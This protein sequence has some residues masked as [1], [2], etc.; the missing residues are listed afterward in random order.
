MT[1]C[2]TRKGAFV[3]VKARFKSLLN[4]EEMVAGVD[5]VRGNRAVR[6]S[7]KKPRIYIE[8]PNFILGDWSDAN[9]KGIISILKCFFLASGLQINIHKSQVLGVGVPRLIVERAASNLGCSIMQ[10]QFRYLG[11]LVGACMSRKKAWDDIVT[12]LRSRLSKWKVKTL[13]IGGRLTLL[14]SVLGASPLYSMSIFKAP[15]GVLKE[16]E[17]VRRQFFYGADH[18]DNK[19]TWAAWNKILA[20]KQKGGL[21][22]SSFHALNRAL[23]LKWVWRFVSQDGSLW[24]R[25]IQAIYGNTITNHQFMPSHSEPSRWVRYIPIKINVFAWRARRDCLPTRV[26]LMRRGVT[27]DSVNCPFCNT[28]E[29]DIHHVLFRCE[30]A[31]AVMRRVC[32]WWTLDWQPWSS[33]SDWN[34]WFSNVRFFSKVKRVLEGVFC[35]AWWSL[36]KLRNCTI[37]DVSPPFRS[38]IFDDIVYDYYDEK[39]PDKAAS[40]RFGAPL[41]DNERSRDVN[42][43]ANDTCRL[44]LPPHAWHEAAFTR[45]ARVWGDVMFPKKCN[46]NNNNLVA[47]KGGKDYGEDLEDED[48]IFDDGSE[49]DIF[50]HQD[51]DNYQGE[52]G[53]I[54]DGVSDKDPGEHHDKDSP[55]KGRVD[56][57]SEFSKNLVDFECHANLLASPNKDNWVCQSPTHSSKNT[58]ISD[59][60]DRTKMSPGN[61]NFDKVYSRKVVVNNVTSREQRYVPIS[62][63]S[64]VDISDA[65]SHHVQHMPAPDKTKT[66]TGPIA[67]TLNSPIMDPS[68]IKTSPSKQCLQAQPKQKKTTKTTKNVKKIASLKL[69]HPAIGINLQTTKRKIPLSHTSNTA[70]SSSFHNTSIS[71]NDYSIQRCKTRLLKNATFTNIIIINE[72]QKTIDIGS[73]IGYDLAGK[74]EMESKY[75]KDDSSFIH[76]LWGFRSCG[77]AIKKSDGNSSGI[78]AIWNKSMFMEQNAVYGDVFLAAYGQWIHFNTPCLMIIVCAPQEFECKVALWNNLSN[79]VTNFNSPS[80]VFRDFNEVREEA[81]R[82]GS[83][84]VIGWATKKNERLFFLKVDFE[85]AFDSLDWKFL[86]HIM[87]QIGF[88]SAYASVLINGSPTKEFKINKGLRQGDPLS[89]FLFIFA[90]EALHVSLQEA[91]MKNVFQGVK[92]LRFEMGDHGL[93]GRRTVFIHSK[94]TSYAGVAGAS[95]SEP[96]KGKANFRPLVSNNL[97]D[98]VDLIIPNKVVD[99]GWSSF[100]RCLIEVKA[101]VALKDNITIG[102]PLPDGMGFFKETV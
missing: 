38:E 49:C 21:G 9:L 1:A 15:K 97:C 39:F 96:L 82:L 85:K 23:L 64:I 10:N 77:F 98:G 83:I 71:N 59:T 37:F 43:Q 51:F 45:I 2:T 75:N 12:K 25:V 58:H 29:E 35:V 70:A 32:R 46:E 91:K 65:T 74:E 8:I 99:M 94:P 100:A 69:I 92:L 57:I 16:L 60:L 44:G 27:L 36:W 81:E 66:T 78:I 63:T 11:V 6:T 14:K 48:D 89:P 101:D 52:G 42:S 41:V 73:S 67:K 79:L 76:S 62:P 87:E 18:L 56:D 40:T 17:A 84:F 3:N 53:W 33:F 93:T 13:S 28:D 86:D 7:V 68:L 102:I 72:I 34:A 4:V 80:L 55:E 5:N 22:V 31:T 47:G 50:L 54:G 61:C 24:S 19:I 26:N 20:S 95:L 88:Y 30:V 90:A